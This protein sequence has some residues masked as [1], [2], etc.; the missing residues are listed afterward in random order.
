M[1]DHHKTLSPSNLPALSQCIHFERRAEIVPSAAAER[2]TKVHEYVAK[3]L[4]E[5][6]IGAFPNEDIE[7]VKLAEYAAKQ[8]RE[9]IP[10]LRGLEERISLHD[11]EEEITFGTLDAWGYKWDLRIADIKTGRQRDYSAQLHAYALAKMD[12]LGEDQA[13]CVIIYCDLEIVED[14]IVSKADAERHIFWII[15]RI[16]EG[17]EEPQE[18]YYCDYCAKRPTCPVWT[19]PAQQA[20][21]LFSGGNG[22]T[23]VE[24]LEL[25]KDNPHLLGAFLSMMHKAEK[26]ISDAGLREKAKEYLGEK[27]AVPGWALQHS[28]GRRF[29]TED[30][31]ETVLRQMSP[32]VLRSMVTI[33]A[34]QLEK[35]WQAG[36]NAQE[37]LPAECPVVP[38]RAESFTKL[39]RRDK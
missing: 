19:L 23:P 24:K 35:K 18:N 38:Q 6:T 11:G 17:I 31:V 10:S 16:K 1:T 30:Q 25:I 37:E 13:R 7:A 15:N 33:D 20:I 22:L 28:R 34:D 8:I 36:W 12:E 14:W 39:I 4:R 2:G 32:E 3:L 26:L 21:D 5:E 27:V 9:Y 29:F